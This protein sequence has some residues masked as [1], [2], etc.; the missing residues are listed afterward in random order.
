MHDWGFQAT[1][2][3]HLRDGIVVGVEEAAAALELLDLTISKGAEG[4]VPR[5]LDAA[6]AVL[7]SENPALRRDSRFAR[8]AAL[9][10]A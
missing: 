1:D 2:G 4:R 5:G 8:L 10:R 9:V 6:L 3:D 7:A